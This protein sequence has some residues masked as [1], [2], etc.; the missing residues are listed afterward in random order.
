MGFLFSHHVFLWFQRLV[1]SGLCLFL[2]RFFVKL[3][4]LRK[5]PGPA[6]LPIIGNCYDPDIFTSIKFLGKLRKRYGKLFCFWAGPRPAIVVCDPEIVRQILTKPK[7]YTKTKD[8][9]KVFGAT[10]FGNGLVTSEDDVHKK[11]RALFTKF[12]AP[13]YLEQKFPFFVKQIDVAI[14][15]ILEPA[16]GT[17]LDIQEFFHITALRIFGAHALSIDFS[18]RPEEARW[19]IKAC[20][21][22]SKVVGDLMMQGLPPT[23]IFPKVNR[24]FP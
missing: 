24:N 4:H 12:F 14:D 5:I 13:K 20:K 18:S 6:P 19:A 15:E 22:G 10:G 17:S 8:Y 16:V 3:W 23:R 7:I 21:L 1:G 9:I 11:D 2:T